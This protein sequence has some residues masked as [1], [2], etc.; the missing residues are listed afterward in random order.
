M[1][2]ILFHTLIFFFA[3][4]RLLYHSPSNVSITAKHISTAILYFFSIPI[5]KLPFYPYQSIKSTVLSNENTLLF[6]ENTLLFLERIA[7][8]Q[9]IRYTK[10]NERKAGFKN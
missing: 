7:E 5:K 1:K 3:S 4:T 8:K 6:L 9:A 10:S 2:S